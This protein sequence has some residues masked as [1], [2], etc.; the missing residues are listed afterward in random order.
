MSA[1]D[2]AP[3]GTGRRAD[4]RLTPCAVASGLLMVRL[5]ASVVAIADP[6]S[7]ALG[8][9]VLVSL[10]S[11]EAGATLTGELT[12]AGVPSALAQQLRQAE[13]AVAM[14]VSPVSADMPA[15]I[16]AAVVEGSGQAFLDGPLCLVGAAL[17][18]LVASGGRGAARRPAEPRGRRPGDGG[19]H[20]FRG[21]AVPFVR[22]H[23]QSVGVLQRS[24]APSL[25]STVTRWK[26]HRS[27]E[28]CGS[29]AA[30]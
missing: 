8:T 30:D 19:V 7:G 24:P 12:D 21:R 16:R 15:G 11:G 14:G 6:A 23:R 2:A 1:A 26:L 25:G 18:A 5:D 9:S 29:G 3:P 13:D 20:P 10:I 17:A 4:P 28:A 27:A 22:G